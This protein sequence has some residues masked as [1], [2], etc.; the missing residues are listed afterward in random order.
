MHCTQ[1]HECIIHMYN[2]YKKKCRGE[3]S[4]TPGTHLARDGLAVHH[5]PLPQAY[6]AACWPLMHVAVAQN[7]LDIA[8][9]GT[10]GMVLYDR[11][12]SRWRVFG[13]VRQERAF[14]TRALAWL[15]NIVICCRVD[16]GGAAGGGGDA[17]G[18]FSGDCSVVLHSRFHL[19]EASVLCRLPLTQV[20]SS[21]RVLTCIY[22]YYKLAS[23]MT[24]LIFSLSSI[25]V[26]ALHIRFSCQKCCV[27]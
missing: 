22:T 21:H 2:T 20:R 17:L 11:R 19:D 16:A 9:A 18:D 12:Q 23:C 24:S 15:P 14:R 3:E 13:D 8:V 27:Y 25:T 5:A 10:H 4:G 7:I 26:L 1:K 6:T